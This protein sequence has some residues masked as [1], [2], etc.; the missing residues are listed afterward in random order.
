MADL[1]RDELEAAVAARRELGSEREP[2]LV[3][4]FLARIERQIDARVDEKL[5]RRGSAPARR[6]DGSDW[7]AAILGIAS[8]GIGIGATGSATSQGAGWVAAIAWIAIAL[9]NLAYHFRHRI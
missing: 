3:E 7:A 5:G 9:V 8:L 6:R 1:P 2:E 4:S